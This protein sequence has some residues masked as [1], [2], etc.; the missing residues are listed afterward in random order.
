MNNRFM[1]ALFCLAT[2]QQLT[3]LVLEMQSTSLV[4]E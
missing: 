3:Q 4:K 1:S 2:I